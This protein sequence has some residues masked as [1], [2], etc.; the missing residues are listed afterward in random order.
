M[1]SFSADDLENKAAEQR[2]RIDTSVNELT[3]RLKEKVNLNNLAREHLVPMAAAGAVLGLVLGYNV[4][5]I[6]VHR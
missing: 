2:R 5:G 1:N 3:E 4:T 6:F